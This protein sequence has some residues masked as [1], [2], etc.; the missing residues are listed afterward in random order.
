MPISQRWVHIDLAERTDRNADVRQ[1]LQ[2][3]SKGER[4][5]AALES[6]LTR[7]EAKIDELLAQAE[8]E[9]QEVKSTDQSAS[10]SGAE[11]S[12]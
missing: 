2:E 9:Q 1:A 5:A 6:Q 7:M 12:Q 8:Q 4:T 3:L 10:N 11:G